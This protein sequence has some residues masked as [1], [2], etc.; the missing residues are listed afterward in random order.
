MQTDNQNKPENKNKKTVLTLTIVTVLMFGFAFAMV[1]LYRIICDV[2]G[3]NSISTND[4]RARSSEMEATSNSETRKVLVQFDATINGNLNWEFKPSVTQMEVVLGKRTNTSY[5]VKNNSHSDVVTQSIP[6]V[7]P[8]QATEFLTKVECF[9][10]E[11]QTVLAGEAKD[12]G[13]QFVIDPKLPEDIKTV[14]LS[15]TIMDTDRTEA[16]KTNK[17]NLPS[18]KPNMHEHNHAH[19]SPSES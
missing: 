15:Y 14:T 4:G 10:F 3:L 7:T 6:G 18:L 13:L 12:M 5:F 11:N 9:C 8:W 16:L 2:T 19:H 17:E 1:P